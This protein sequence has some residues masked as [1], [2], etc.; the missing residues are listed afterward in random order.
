M[1]N[2]RNLECPN[3]RRSYAEGYTKGRNEAYEYFKSRLE[4]EPIAPIIIDKDSELIPLLFPD[5]SKENMGDK[6]NC[7]CFDCSLHQENSSPD[8]ACES[9]L[10]YNRDECMKCEKRFFC[11]VTKQPHLYYED[12]ETEPNSVEYRRS[13]GKT[14]T[15]TFVDE[16]GPVDRPKKGN[17]GFGYFQ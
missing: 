1:S 5:K 6:V 7:I 16:A 4:A 17:P 13:R 15:F 2:Y 10:I 14:H 11:D 8:C 9:A 12:S 3:C